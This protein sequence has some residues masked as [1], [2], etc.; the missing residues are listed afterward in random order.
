MSLT[1]QR[2][3]GYVLCPL[4]GSGLRFDRTA[5][6]EGRTVRLGVSGLLY[7]S[8]LVMWDRETESLWSQMKLEAISGPQ[9]RA[10]SPLQGVFE[11]T[12]G[13]WKALHDDTL[14]VSDET[15]VA[16]NYRHYPYEDYRTDHS[17]TFR[18]T[19]PKPDTQFENKE[20]VFGVIIEGEAKAYVWSRLRA[21]LGDAGIVFDEMGGVPIAVVFHGPSRF[22]HA[23]DRRVG[24]K[25]QRLIL[26]RH[27]Q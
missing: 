15:G 22:V 27:P 14:V 11:M 7:N 20:L 23:F 25:M 5:F 19:N 3:S 18:G 26:S 17:N 21:K 16:R 9:I 13:A 12:W 1:P 10:A 6:V 2:T 8:N 4:T 24:G